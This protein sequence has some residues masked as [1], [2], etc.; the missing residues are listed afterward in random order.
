MF[1]KPKT[2]Q[3][4]PDMSKWKAQPPPN[5]DGNA[6][7]SGAANPDVPP[8]VCLPIPVTQESNIASLPNNDPVGFTQNCATKVIINDNVQQWLTVIDLK[9]VV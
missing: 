1:K 4:I 6:G 5:E 7:G 3:D 8:V 2:T 9:N